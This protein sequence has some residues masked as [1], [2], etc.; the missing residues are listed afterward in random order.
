MDARK[1]RLAMCSHCR[2][3]PQAA[4][5]IPRHYT[6]CPGCY[7][8]PQVRRML[9][10]PGQLM[11]PRGVKP[12]DYEP[13]EAMPGTREKVAVRVEN[14]QALIVSMVYWLNGRMQWH[15]KT[16]HQGHPLDQG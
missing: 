16:I 1:I 15:G 9:G 6:L 10:V 4:S 13:T 7:F 5:G 3:R 14:G 12:E 8:S 2:Q 11:A